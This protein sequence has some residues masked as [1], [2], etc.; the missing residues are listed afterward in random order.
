MDRLTR[1]LRARCKFMRPRN[2]DKDTLI[3]ARIPR[4]FRSARL[5]NIPEEYGYRE[6]L[7][8]YANNAEE[9]GKNG[10]GMILYGP[11]G[12]GK[13]SAAC[14]VLRVFLIHDVPALFVRWN[15]LGKLFKGWDEE[16]KE[17]QERVMWIRA[18]VI[19]DVGEK[20]PQ[21]FDYTHSAFIQVLRHRFDE[22]LPTF[23][24]LNVEPE[25]F[26]RLMDSQSSLLS[27]PR[28]P[29]IEVRGRNWR[30]EAE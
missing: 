2:P 6:L 17:L 13:T 24:T 12:H 20:I 21:D 3:H 26:F 16:S 1:R 30:E 11:H 18:L 14:A 19:D 23:L 9:L 28:F 5:T 29:L 8:T 27:S 4:E 25:T 22:K 15:E 7:L 10:S